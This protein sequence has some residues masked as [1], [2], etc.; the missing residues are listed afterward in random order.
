MKRQILCVI[1]AAA[2]AGS[3]FA[4]VVEDSGVKGGLVVHLGCGDGK[5]TARLRINDSYIVHGLDTDAEAVADARKHIQSLGIYGKAT[6]D[7]FD[8][9]NLPYIDNLVNLLVDESGKSKVPGDEIL[10]VLAPGG[11]AVIKGVRTV[12]PVPAEIDEWT[13]YLHGPDNNAVANDSEVGPPRHMQWLAGPRWTRNHHKLNSVSS[14]VTAGG[15]LF[16]IMDMATPANMSIKG[17]WR[18]IARDAFNGVELWRRE[19]KSWVPHT[20]GFRSGPPH[21]TRLLVAS[22]DRVYAP[23]GNLDPIS[24]MDAATGK[25]VKTYDCTA[26][27]EEIILVGDILLAQLAGSSTVPDKSVVAVSTASGKKLW[28]WTA[29][30]ATLVPETLA[31][32]G[33]QAYVQVNN[34]VICLN[35]KTGKEVWRFGEPGTRKMKMRGYGK[36][37]LVVSDGVVLC[38]L[39]GKLTA[40]SAK[41]G[42]KLWEQQGG[43]GFHAPRD[44]FVIDGL[45]WPG[46]HPRDSVAPPPVDDFSKAYDLHTGSLKKENTIMVDIQTAGHHHRCYREKATSRYII[47]GKRGFE[48]MDLKGDNHARANWVRGT[49]QYGMM[50]ANGLTY[51][52]PHSCGCYMESLLKGFYA[53]NDTQPALKKR[54]SGIKAS[55]RLDKGPAY[56]KT[57]T[58]NKAPGD[59]SWPQYRRDALRTGVSG[60]RVPAELERAWKIDVGGKLTQPVIADGKVVFAAVDQNTVYAADEKTGKVL[61]KKTVGGRVDSPPAIHKGAVLFGC[62]DGR[63]YC[64]RLSDGR[65]AWRFLA[66]PADI[67]TVALEQVE[68]LWPLHGSVLLLNGTIY[69][70][71]GRSTWIDGGIDMYALAPATGKVVHKYHYES[72]HPVR[73]EGKDKAKPEHK[74]GNSQNRSDYKTALQPDRA[75]SFSMAGGSVRDVL[76]SDGRNVFMHHATFNAKLEP[77]EKMARHL[78]STSG[79][80]DGAENH[81]SHWVMGSGD[82]SMVAVA[83]SWIVNGGRWGG[84]SAQ[85]GLMMAYD[86]Q[87]IWVVRRKGY[88]LSKKQNKPFS[89]DEESVNDFTRKNTGGARKRKGAQKKSSQ[90]K[91]A[92]KGTVWSVALGARPRAIIKAGDHLFLGTIPSQAKGGKDPHAAYEGRVSGMITVVSDKEGKKVIEHKLDAPVVWDG[93]AAADGKLFVALENGSIECWAGK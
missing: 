6:A 26:G 88:T 81:R 89:D 47:T 92:D 83:Y 11:V 16:Y 66:A 60:T 37:T 58:G 5:E 74:K 51:A 78:F 39:P 56:E 75:D 77:Q 67:R 46:S 90:N 84:A 32:D 91:P 10:R 68:S 61:W 49:C 18:I 57:N 33:S 55:E 21:V 34:S 35:L 53:L 9:K 19:I 13:H 22:K 3:A 4:G 71:A 85:F 38:N 54:V 73:N 79:M 42:K 44:V 8:G 17:K 27:T 80:L 40:I 72:R 65:L 48:I 93:M 52:P 28:E 62:A 69:C 20:T 7:T 86:H 24:A 82:F 15:R 70:A 30:N 1:V 50:P 36:H 25:I 64:L 43:A 23:L 87:A 63:V 14:V 59:E 41:D 76:V 2:L 12:K 31:S 45:V 29:P